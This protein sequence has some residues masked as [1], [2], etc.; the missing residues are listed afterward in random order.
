MSDSGND[1][2]NNP[3]SIDKFSEEEKKEIIE[4]MKA[5]LASDDGDKVILYAALTKQ[6]L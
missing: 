3:K 2:A 4:K 5:Y 1:D 6:L